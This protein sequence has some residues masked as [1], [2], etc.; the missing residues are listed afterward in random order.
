MNL[1][2]EAEQASSPPIGVSDTGNLLHLSLAATA[3]LRQ[4]ADD[5]I[6]QLNQH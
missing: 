4:V 5:H 2:A 3:L 1:D 6:A